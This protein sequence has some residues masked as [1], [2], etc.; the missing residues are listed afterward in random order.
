MKRCNWTP[1]EIERLLELRRQNNH[2]ED[3]A[4]LLGRSDMAV[5]LKL[6][7]L[8]FSSR[9]PPRR[10]RFATL[11][12]ECADVP[13]QIDTETAE[14]VGTDDVVDCRLVAA[15]GECERDL[16]EDLAVAENRLAFV[17]RRTIEQKYHALLRSRCLDDRIVE[18][19]SSRIESF[20]P[21][22]AELSPRH[23]ERETTLALQESA[24]LLLGDTHIGQIV[25]PAQTGSLGNYNLRRYCEQ[26]AFLEREVLELLEQRSGYTDELVVFLLGDILH[27][28]L[29]HG[30]E[31][32]ATLLL[33][34]QYQLAIWTLH[35]FLCRLASAVPL[36]RVHTV[37]G[38]H[39][40]LPTQRRMPTV[41]RYSNFDFL[42]YAALEQSL[43]AAAPG[44]I[45]FELNSGPRQ[46]VSVK[47]TRLLASH[48]DHLRGGGKDMALPLGAMARDVNL[49]TQRHAVSNE[50]PVDYYLIGDKHK[51]ASLPLPTGAY[52]INGAFSGADEFSTYNF[53]LSEPVQLLFWLHPERKKTW[54]YEVKLRW[55]P[56]LTELPYDL[57]PRLQSLVHQSLN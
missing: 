51:S 49:T 52:L 30:A 13:E 20:S 10:S 14:V 42:V 1:V 21:S 53:P 41:G 48:G 17:D 22:T 7:D 12:T 37:V 56:R 47:G 26:L 32:E 54:Q 8:D 15:N 27:G 3:I 5:R 23:V 16:R 2:T 9:N 29:S 6:K 43:Q 40:R 19:F 38:N 31:R 33:A 11:P 35:Q 36:L 24:V 44:R 46:L 55:A 4:R 18:I 50:A 39:G 28:C 57:P 34:D 25:D 45:E